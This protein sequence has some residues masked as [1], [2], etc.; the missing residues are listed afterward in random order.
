MAC[1]VDGVSEEAA[2]LARIRWDLERLLPS[3]CVC[4]FVSLCVCVC[5]WLYENIGWF[6]LFP[7]SVSFVLALCVE[8]CRNPE[9]CS[10]KVM[11]LLAFKAKNVLEE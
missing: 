6:R 1:G 8:A 10:R 5:S 3:L 11:F 4:L 9:D 7:I 2:H